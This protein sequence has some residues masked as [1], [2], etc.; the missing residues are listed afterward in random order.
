[1]L[2]DLS[3]LRETLFAIRLVREHVLAMPV[4]PEARQR[5]ASRVLKANA[6]PPSSRDLVR[7]ALAVG[8]ASGLGRVDADVLERLAGAAGG[9]ARRT[10]PGVPF[11]GRAAPAPNRIDALL[12]EML[13]TLNA[14]VAAET[15]PPV[16]R[17]FAAH[18]LVRIVQPFEAPAGALGAA[19]E[20]SLLAADGIAADRFLLPEADVGADASPGRPDPDLFVRARMHRLVDRMA[21][22]QDLVRAETARAVLLGWADDR[23][24]K[25]NVRQRRLLRWLA[26]GDADRSLEFRDYVRLHA[27]RRAPS[28]RSLQRDWKGLREGGVVAERDGHLVVDPDTL[29][30]GVRG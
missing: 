12:A 8:V 23:A 29:A 20:A 15:W 2:A 16:V 25:L 11:Q 1:M 13:E 28:L 26:E 10:G 17:A 9:A 19:L 21:E 4:R 3:D 24:A 27:G 14:P 18:F 30:F 5:V 6:A 22:T 7:A